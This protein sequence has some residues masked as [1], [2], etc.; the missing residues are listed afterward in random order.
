MSLRRLT[1]FLAECDCCDRAL[2]IGV[3]RGGSICEALADRG[4]RYRHYVKVGWV[5]AKQPAVI[6]VVRCPLHVLYEAGKAD[7]RLTR[8]RL[9]DK[10]VAV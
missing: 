6:D 3:W 5:S 7:Q 10:K 2:E 9:R 8:Y 1:Y 4:W